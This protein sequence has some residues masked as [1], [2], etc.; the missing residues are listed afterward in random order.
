MRK[1]M[2][3]GMAALCSVALVGVISSPAAVAKAH[4]AATT[5]KKVLVED[6]TIY[7]SI[8]DPNPGNLPSVGFEATQGY[9]IGNGITFGGASRVLD[10]VVV[11]MSSWGCSQSGGWT[12]TFEYDPSSTPLT[13]P[14]VTTPGATF[15]EPITLN[16]Y[17]APSL[18]ESAPQGTLINPGALIASDTQTFTLP[19][20]PSA[21]PNF[22][23]DCLP[24]VT[25]S[26]PIS[27]FNGTWYDPALSPTTGL[28]IGCLNGLLANIQFN[29]G[30]VT[31]PDSVVYGISYN[32]SDYGFP[33]DGYSP[34]CHATQQGC[35]YDSLNVALSN[36]NPG[37]SVGSDPNPGTI[38]WDSTY[39]GFYCDGSFGV[40][41]FRLDSPGTGN[42]CWSPYIPAVQFN[43]V[44]SPSP[45]ITSLNYASA[46]AGSPFSFTVTTTGV[47]VP[48]VQKL[49][50]KLPRGITLVNNGNGTATIAG[51]ALT[52]DHNG[53]YRMAVRAKNARNSVAK[54]IFMLTLTGGRS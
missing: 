36:E 41:V 6:P 25:P 8:V 47:P 45:S 10:N 40:G 35:G 43:A 51:T 9:E 29:F 19:Y 21:D 1:T 38:Y 52:T 50:G 15:T 24:D 23:T 37:P 33:A 42:Q 13:D 4:R 11:Q 44:S 48:A 17:G 18:G 2:L 46:V 54:Q 16:I 5:N 31:L 12:G 22:A 32:T 28:P 49:S 14:C 30:H 34:P 27:S 20:R 39:A 3:M 7:D 53:V 26:S